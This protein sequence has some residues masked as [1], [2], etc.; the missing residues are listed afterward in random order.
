MKYWERNVLKRNQNHPELSFQCFF[1]SCTQ[2]NTFGQIKT[3]LYFP[4]FLF[5]QWSLLLLLPLFDRSHPK[6]DCIIIIYGKFIVGLIYIWSNTSSPIRF[7]SIK[8]E[9]CLMSPCY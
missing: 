1:I 9:T 7:T 3:D 4:S 2:I 5:E 6:T 8:K